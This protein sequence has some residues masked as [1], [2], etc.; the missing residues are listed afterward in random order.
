MKNNSKIHEECESTL[1]SKIIDKLPESSLSKGLNFLDIEEKD[2]KI[3]KSEMENLGVLDIFS[4]CL[5]SSRLEG[6]S[7]LYIFIESDEQENPLLLD[8]IKDFR[9]IELTD[10]QI[11]ESEK[12]DFEADIKKKYF[13]KVEFYYLKIDQKEEVKIHASRLLIFKGVDCTA[14]QLKENKGKYKSFASRFQES[15]DSYIK[16]RKNIN[17]LSDRAVMPILKSSIVSKFIEDPLGD[18]KKI[19]EERLNE[20][21]N[22]RDISGL[23]LLDKDED[24]ILSEIEGKASFPAY[25]I[26][27]NNLS[28][29]TEVPK[30]MLFNESVG[31]ENGM[32][33]DNGGWQSDQWEQTKLNYQKF[34]IA[35]NMHKILKV[36]IAKLK[37][38]IEKNKFWEFNNDEELS[39]DQKL[40]RQENIA[41]IDEIYLKNGVLTPSQ[42]A[43]HRFTNNGFNY[44]SI[45]VER[46]EV[47]KEESEFEH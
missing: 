40:K 12:N 16:A 29:D 36:I 26:I 1:Y 43:S 25:E 42:V 28:I 35:D 44:G 45:V 21:V 18:G 8:G 10:K 19:L 6:T 30:S 34:Y 9:L 38:K 37:I 11:K 20:I 17:I 32:N 39:T 46:E 3:L 7:Y 23:N 27:K 14:K 24:Y 13:N 41:K 2:D 31:G 4:R 22:G 33:F 15:F 5:K 47:E